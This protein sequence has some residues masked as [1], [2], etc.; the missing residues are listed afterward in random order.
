MHANALKTEALDP[1]H[2]Y[3]PWVVADGKTDADTQDETT[4]DLF[5]WVCKH[6]Q[7]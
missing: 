6:Y 7:G 1:P 3:T 4:D 5:G 2:E